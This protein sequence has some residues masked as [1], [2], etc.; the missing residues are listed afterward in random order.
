ME[1]E[2]MDGKELAERLATL[3]GSRDREPAVPELR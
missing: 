1:R 3:E 2:V